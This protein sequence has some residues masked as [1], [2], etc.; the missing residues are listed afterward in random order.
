MH[1]TIYGIAIKN[2]H[3]HCVSKKDTTKPPMMAYSLSNVC[4]KDY[5][6]RTTIVE[7]IIGG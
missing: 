5:W 4:T 7:I 6:N 2:M 3:L 1:V